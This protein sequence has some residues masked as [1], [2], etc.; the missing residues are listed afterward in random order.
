MRLLVA[1]IAVLGLSVSAQRERPQARASERLA[2]SLADP[3]FGLTFDPASVRYELMPSEMKRVCTD[4]TDGPYRIFAQVT[5]GSTAYLVVLGGP[6][7]RDGDLF[8][9][10]VAV[11]GT[12]CV[13]DDSNWVLSGY[14]PASGYTNTNR[15][16]ALPGN[17]APRICNDGPSGQCHYEFQS[18][19]EETL[20]RDLGRDALLRATRA[21]G[22][23]RFRR[24]V[25]QA[26]E[27]KEM[28]ASPVVQQELT[29]FCAR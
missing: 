9:A 17:D 21:W 3:I 8:G 27:V 7:G 24:L 26:E 22:D 1:M 19:S 29:R 25:C 10:A 14:V 6:A 20:L 13:I 12:R 23:A 28:A 5:R 16:R 2:D 15:T 4:F 11:S 18:L